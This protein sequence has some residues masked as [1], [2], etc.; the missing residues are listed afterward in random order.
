MTWKK[1]LLEGDAAGGAID[2]QEG[3]VS[4]VAAA[5]GL[6]F[7]ATDFAITDEGGNVAG[8]ALDYPNSKI[9]RKDQ[10]EVISGKWL[11]GDT[12]EGLRFGHAAGPY[13]V[14]SGAGQVLGLSGALNVSFMATGTVS[15][16]Q[17]AVAGVG[18]LGH[19][20]N[21]PSLF[22]LYFDARCYLASANIN[23]LYG[24]YVGMWLYTTSTITITEAG[25]LWVGKQHSGANMT[26]TNGYGIK[27]DD[28]SWTGMAT[29]TALKIAD[30]A[31]GT[32]RY[33]ME[34]GAPYLRVVGGSDPNANESNMYLKLG[35]TLKHVTE[36]AA[37]SGGAGLRALCVPN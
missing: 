17:K 23:Y 34:I 31:Y 20:G 30:A 16:T 27:V 7:A 29:Y 22:G 35:A 24:A 28:L 18:G 25:G 21:T 26:I 36:G 5:T 9:C 6:N 14:G 3:G 4:V 37:D 13:L 15:G 11:I 32:T 33:L 1:M 2:V 12:A 8:I 10:D 19:T